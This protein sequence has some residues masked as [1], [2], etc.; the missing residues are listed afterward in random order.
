MKRFIAYALLAAMIMAGA[1]SCGKEGGS[2]RPIAYGVRTTGSITN[3][4]FIDDKGI[5]HEIQELEKGVMKPA[6]EPRVLATFD[7]LKEISEKRYAIRLTSLFR[8]LIKDAITLTGADEKDLAQDPI[9]IQEGWISAGYLNIGFTFTQK[10]ESET[11][12]T[13]NLVLDDTQPSDTL[14]F[15]LRHNG[16]GEG[17][18]N[19]GDKNEY[20]Y[21]TGFACFKIESMMPEGKTEIPI[22]ITA[23]WYEIVGDGILTGKTVIVKNET[24]YKK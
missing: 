4:V 15:T 6:D 8:P 9:F 12:H 24:V 20:K 1:A 17:L 5:E 2:K 22:T 23:P 21:G 13:L 18:A 7:L 11:P 3:G 19:E 16:A 10:K 14:R